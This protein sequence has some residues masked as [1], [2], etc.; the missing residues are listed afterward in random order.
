[1]VKALSVDLRKRVV[2][3]IDGGIS[4]NQAAA[5]FGVSIASAVRWCQ[6]K[7]RQGDISPKRQGIT[8]E[9][10]DRKSGRIESEA[11]FILA[12]IRKEP[13]ITL[14]ELQALL[15]QRKQS[16]GLATLWR[17]FHRHQIT[18]KKS[19]PTRQNRNVLTS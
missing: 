4:R 17:F 18:L 6:L 1:M 2:A 13:D 16:F 3:A 8:T 14:A 19:R 9:G 11:P 15:H 7:R 10:G 12:T 5:R